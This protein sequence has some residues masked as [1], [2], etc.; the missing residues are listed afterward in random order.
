MTRPHALLRAGFPYLKT[1]GMRRMTNFP[2]DLAIGD[3]GRLYLL[4]RADAGGEIRVWHWD[5]EDLGSIGSGGTGDGQFTWPVAIVRDA[6]GNLMVTDEA[7]NRVSIF[8]EDGVFLSSWGE[9]G[10]G[11]GRLNRPTGLALDGDGDV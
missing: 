1:I 4:L 6:D 7:L 10:Q 5:D 2:V 8:D 9:Q 3:E 11:S